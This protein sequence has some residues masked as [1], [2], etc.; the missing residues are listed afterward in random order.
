MNRT[1]F[2]VLNIVITLAALGSFIRI[3]FTSGFSIGST[4]PDWVIMTYIAC[5][6]IPVLS[7]VMYFVFAKRLK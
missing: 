5:A 3:F 4:P 7:W 2:K 1:S 6:V